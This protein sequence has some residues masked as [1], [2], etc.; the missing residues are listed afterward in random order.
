MS[1]LQRE[2]RRDGL[3][4]GVTVAE[5]ERARGLAPFTV[6]PS[7]AK[8]SSFG[9]RGRFMYRNATD[10]EREAIAENR[11][12]RARDVRATLPRVGPARAEERAARRKELREARTL[13]P[14]KTCPQFAIKEEPI[15][16]RLAEP[17]ISY[18]PTESA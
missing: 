13:R 2:Y 12:R 16:F 18:R 7:V 8:A 6:F 4:L 10:E 17:L 3:R 15:P 1:P 5:W 9:D 11:P 14:L